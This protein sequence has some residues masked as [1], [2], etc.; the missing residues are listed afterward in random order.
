MSWNEIPTSFRFRV[1]LFKTGDYYALSSCVYVA[2]FICI[3][4]AANGSSGAEASGA[5]STVGKPRSAA[6]DPAY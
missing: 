4:A 2:S 5:A 1:P 3:G 6:D